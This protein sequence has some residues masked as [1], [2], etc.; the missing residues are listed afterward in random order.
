MGQS[1][2][3]LFLGRVAAAA[4]PVFTRVIAVQRAGTETTPLSTIF[5]A[6]HDDEA[7]VF[8]VAA[9]IEHARNPC[10]I[11]ATDYAFITTEALR[12][13]RAAFERSA[14][15]LVLP[16]WDGKPQLLCGGY[17]PAVLPAIRERVRTGKLDLRGL[18]QACLTETLAESDLR[19]RFEA[20]VFVNVNTPADLLAA[21]SP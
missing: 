15:D 13:V 18:M 7:P 10:F 14:A 19:S 16:E 4:A 12:F 17:R 1:K 20:R 5:E 21:E 11:L 3:E 6:V 9:A 2:T 8:G